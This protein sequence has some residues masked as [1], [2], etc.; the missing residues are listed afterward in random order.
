M[1]HSLPLAS[2]FILP[3]ESLVQGV[4]SIDVFF[5]TENRLHAVA[6]RLAHLFSC[7]RI[8]QQ[9]RYSVGEAADVF[10]L[11]QKTRLLIDHDFGKSADARRYD[12]A[13]HPSRLKRHQWK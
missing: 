10:A 2:T 11:E 5:P 8:V 1:Y 9:E 3:N 4:V 13:S 6:S 12:R 7:F